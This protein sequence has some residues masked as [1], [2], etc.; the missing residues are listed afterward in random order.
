MAKIWLTFKYLLS[1]FWGYPPMDAPAPLAQT[2]IGNDF[3]EKNTL[4]KVILAIKAKR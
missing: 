3:Q 4:F 1:I 2:S